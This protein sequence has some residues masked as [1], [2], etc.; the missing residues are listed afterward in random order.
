M[1]ARECPAGATLEKVIRLN[2]IPELHIRAAEEQ[3]AEALIAYMHR[4]TN[5]PHNN[6]S[7]D[8]GQWTM[9]VDEERVFL[10]QRSADS[11]KGIFA[12]AKIGHEL[13][14]VGQLDRG[15][16]PTNRHSA[17]LGISVDASWRRQGIAKALMAYLL[18]WAR[19]QDLVRIELKVFT[20]N[21]GAIELYK[22][23]GFVEEGR[24]PKAFCKQGV[25][26]DDITMGL[27]LSS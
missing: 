21:V 8:P 15:S 27:I 12:V 14:G 6:I 23:N 25:W 10:A 11:D 4:L 7:I 26:V 16:R 22:R 2:I 5:E 20:R 18:T 17:T 24:H 3:D 19:Q 1:I 13:V 9:T